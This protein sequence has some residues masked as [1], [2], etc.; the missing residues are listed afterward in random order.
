MT[1]PSKDI[2]H[3]PKMYGGLIIIVLWKRKSRSYVKN[4]LMTLKLLRYLK[5]NK[6]RLRYLKKIQKVMAQYFLLC[7]KYKNML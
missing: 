6:M 2:F 7:K 1:I 4:I 3:Y 5:K